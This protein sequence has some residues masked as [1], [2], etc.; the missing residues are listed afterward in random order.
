MSSGLIQ[1]IHQQPEALRNLLSTGWVGIAE[2]A[3]RIHAFKPE[4]A[5][6]AARGTSDNAARYAQHLFGAYNRLGVGLASPSLFA[7]YGKPPNISRALTIGISQSGRSEDVIAIINEADRQGGLTLAITND[8]GSPLARAA[9]FCIKLSAPKE[10]AANPTMTYTNQLMVLAMLSVAL[11]RA[12]DRWDDLSRIPDILERI[13]E[14]DHAIAESA[15]RFCDNPHFAVI[16]QGFNYCTA[17]EIA[18]KFGQTGDVAA[19]PYS[20]ADLLGGPLAIVDRGFP[21]MFVL[22]GGVPTP[23]TAQLLKIALKQGAQRLVISDQLD[24]LSSA[25]VALPLPAGIPEWLSP[26]AAVVPGQLFAN[27]LAQ[28]RGLNPDM[29]RGRSLLQAAVDEN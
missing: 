19:M 21:M 6:V 16:G 12:T 15:R 23:Q 22:P 11:E 13:L 10:R 20:S 24:L 17:W 28:A 5:F 26:I 1:D 7:V 27:Y 14:Q 4:W 18:L 8:A 9:S 29:P 3:R 2:A 25:D